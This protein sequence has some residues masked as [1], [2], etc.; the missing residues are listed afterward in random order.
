[1]SGV[2]KD[3][4]GSSMMIQTRAWPHVQHLTGDRQEDGWQR[5]HEGLLAAAGTS[6][7]GRK[8]MTEQR[9]GWGRGP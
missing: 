7:E 2:C 1:M 8:T 3:T 4:P 9:E 5:K 6:G